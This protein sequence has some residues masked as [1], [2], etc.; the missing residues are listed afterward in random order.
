ME[1]YRRTGIIGQNEYY[2]ISTINNK[3]VTQPIIKKRKR[4]K[5]GTK[6]VLETE[7]QTFEQN[8]KILNLSDDFILMSKEQIEKVSKNVVNHNKVFPTRNYHIPFDSMK[9]NLEKLEPIELHIKNQQICFSQQ[10]NRTI[11][12]F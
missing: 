6:W 11:C 3:G 1:E 8:K 10:R 7:L 5:E 12:P 4:V 2:R 9:L